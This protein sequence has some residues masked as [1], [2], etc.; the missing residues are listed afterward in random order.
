MPKWG[1]MHWRAKRKEKYE[2]RGYFGIFQIKV[3]FPPSPHF[4]NVFA[5]EDILVLYARKNWKNIVNMDAEM[6]ENVNGKK[7]GIWGINL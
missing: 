4:L 5:L 2:K 6:G 3:P 7:V 1:T